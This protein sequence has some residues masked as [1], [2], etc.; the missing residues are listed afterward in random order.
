MSSAPRPRLVQPDP[1]PDE[2]IPALDGEWA[3]DERIAMIA[4]NAYYRAERRGFVP[5]YDLEDWLAAERA[6]DALLARDR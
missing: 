5:G 3:D 6:I 4:E 2:T 1:M